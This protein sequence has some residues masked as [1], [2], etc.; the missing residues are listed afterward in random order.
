MGKAEHHA[1]YMVYQNNALLHK[2]P[3]HT[4]RSGTKTSR[5]RQSSEML[6]PMS[7]VGCKVCGHANGP[8]VASKDPWITFGTGGAKR[9][10][11]RG[12]SAY[13]IL[14]KARTLRGEPSGSWPVCKSTFFPWIVANAVLAMTRSSTTSADTEVWTKMTKTNAMNSDMFLL[15]RTIKFVVLY[16]YPLVGFCKLVSKLFYINILKL[17]RKRPYAVGIWDI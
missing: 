1:V 6:I 13:G 4:F 14:V 12:G 15:E 3:A 9:R 2:S 8:L 16:K 11:P 10:A 5:Y 17:C 7:H